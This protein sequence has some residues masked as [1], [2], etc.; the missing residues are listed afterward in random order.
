M[1]ATPAAVEIELP[2]RT[3]LARR[4]LLPAAI[5]AWV[6]LV[7]GGTIALARYKAQPGPAAVSPPAWPTDSVAPRRDGLHT[8]V[9]LAHPRCPC[10]MASLAELERLISR[11]DGRAI[12][13]IVFIRP[14]G[15]GDEWRESDLWRRAQQIPGLRLI[16]DPGGVE[17][18][19]FGAYTSGHV[20]LYGPDGH[21]RFSGGITA[22][23]GHEGES[24]GEARILALIGGDEAAGDAPVFGCELDDPSPTGAPRF[25]PEA[26]GPRSSP[27]AGEP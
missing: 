24:A 16:D 17:A 5:I 7:S 8:L 12:A 1:A 13:S 20:L 25:E 15:S 9:M 4:G 23:R 11:V 19:R 26:G 21:L 18:K 2:T 3:P 14:A 6:A 22:A 27:G 10:T